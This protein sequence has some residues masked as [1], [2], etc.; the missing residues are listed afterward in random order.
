MDTPVDGLSLPVTTSADVLAL[1]PPEVRRSTS[2][3]VRDAL[4]AALAE[5]FL[6]YQRRAT[7]SA[8]LGDILRSEGIVLEGLAADHEVYKQPGET[9]DAL[10]L[11]VLTLT[12]LVTPE[13]ILTAVNTIL[14]PFTT[15]TS[16]V[17]VRWVA[18]ARRSCPTAPAC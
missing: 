14:A 5:I 13:V 8:G 16:P 18:L 12:D 9:D 11:R 3:L 15:K 7:R 4:A 2:A 6:E 17:A 1:L 10:R